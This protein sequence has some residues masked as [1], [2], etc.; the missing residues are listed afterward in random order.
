MLKLF[1][2]VIWLFCLLA[3]CSVR[4]SPEQLVDTKEVARILN[5]L[6]ADDMEGRAAFTPGLARAADFIATEFKKIGLQPYTDEPDFRQTFQVTRVSPATWDVTFDGSEIPLEH[7]IVSSNSP[8]VNWNTD[9][10][11]AVI[12]IKAGDDFAQRFREAATGGKDAVVVID[13]SFAG[14]FERYRGFL[15]Q[16][17]INQTA[18]AA[19]K[20][21]SVVYVIASEP[22]KSFRISFTNNIEELPLFNVVGMLPGKSKPDEYVIFSAHY[23]HIGILKADG[24]DSI[25]NGADDDASGVSAVI[26]LANY[27][28]KRNDNARTLVFVAFTAEEIGLVGSQYFSQQVNADEVVA[29]INIEMIGKDSRFGPNSLYVT[30]YNQSNL[31]QIMQQNVKGTDFTFHPDPYPTQNLFYRSDNA[32]LAALGVPAHTFATVQI[33]KDQYYHTVNDEV[34]TLAI[35]NIVSSIKAIALGARSIIAGE[36][37]P[38]RVPKLER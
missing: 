29:M 24:Q 10:G 35:E 30:G 14:M 38:D 26:T 19:G 34:E 22:P 3:A 7:V 28:K 4:H 13:T 23:D 31:A 20:T 37:T 11:V 8:G 33:D 18:G 32:S 1:S 5:T 17:R 6:A 9:P 25:A 21:P 2:R 27:Y 36:D 15:M 16:G 12:Q